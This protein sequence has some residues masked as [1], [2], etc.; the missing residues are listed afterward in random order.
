MDVRQTLSRLPEFLG[1]GQITFTFDRMPIL[2]G[3]LTARQQKN[4]LK[5]GLDMAL[6]RRS[7]LAL[8][9]GIQIEPANVCQLQCPLC[10]SG[11]NLS[12]RPKGFMEYALFER[13]LHDIGDTLVFAVL[14]GWGEPFLNPALPRMI[15]A[16]TERN[17]QTITSTNGHCLQ[18]L[19]E[20][21][22]VVDAGLTALVVAMDGATQETYGAYRVGGSLDKVKRCASL[23]EAAKAKRRSLFPYTNLR[24]VV[25]KNN[26]RELQELERFARDTGFDMFSWKSLGCLTES[27]TFAD[28]EPE[29]ESLCRFRDPRSAARETAPVRCP[30]P[31]RQP[32]VFWDGTVVGC[33]FD[34]S[35]GTEMSLGTIGQQSF[36]AIWNGAAA[37]KLRAMIRNGKVFTQFCRQ[38]PYRGRSQDSSTLGGIPLTDRKVG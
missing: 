19:E 13:I 14:Y 20:A 34:F 36:Q 12:Q 26:A 31:F 11:A 15:K 7:M 21:L 1:R 37:R 4:L 18:S 28:F 22:A 29:A 17:I 25:T 35:E 32:T 16:C 5:T 8:P 6:R 9:P 10:P 23:L 2:A 38:C 27:P 30:Y 33:E 24:V 3:H